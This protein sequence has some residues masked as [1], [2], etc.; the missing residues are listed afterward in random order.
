MSRGRAPALM[1][2]ALAAPLALLLVRASYAAEPLRPG[3]YEMHRTS[4]VLKI[5]SGDGARRFVI[6]T[7]GGN[8][9]TCHI[10]GV[11]RNGTGQGDDAI[12]SPQCKVSFKARN[13]RI[14]V[15]PVAGDCTYYCG[16]RADFAGA[17][18]RPPAAC[19]GDRRAERRASFLARYHDKAFAP[20]YTT[21]NALLREC[22]DFFAWSEIDAVRNDLALTALHLGRPDECR[23]LLKN[24]L[25]AKFGDEDAL[26]EELPPTDF[27]IYVPVARATWHNLALCKKRAGG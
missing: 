11:I 27:E 3:T 26:R 17:Y 23:A 12:A 5:D 9:H 4:G 18:F 6:D 1:R 14:D 7:V 25:G 15:R 21:L 2:L 10:A 19:T 13:D 20:A 8:G 16:A 22:G 24:T